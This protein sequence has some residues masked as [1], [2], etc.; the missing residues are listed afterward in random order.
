V[1]PAVRKEIPKAIRNSY[2]GTQEPTLT[3]IQ[4]VG[5]FPVALYKGQPTTLAA[6][7]APPQLP[8]ETGVTEVDEAEASAL[9]RQLVQVHP[10]GI[11]ATTAGSVV[12]TP[13]DPSSSRITSSRM[14]VMLSAE[15]HKSMTRR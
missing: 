3:I 5:P 14:L 15:R 13:T 11:H 4:Q 12:I 6:F 10:T 8:T 9:F 2:G 1:R 7:T